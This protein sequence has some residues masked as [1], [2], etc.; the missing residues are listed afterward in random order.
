LQE[1]FN[2][3]NKE[4]IQWLNDQW[5]I[6]FERVCEDIDIQGSPER[7][8][9]RVVIEDKK[10]NLYL[11]EKFSRGR[12]FL[13]K[14]VARAIEF[15][16][17][18]GLNQ[19]LLCK[20]SKFGEFLP[21]YRD[22]CF[23]L[24]PFLDSTELRRPDY[25]SSSEIGQNFALFLIRQNEASENMQT[26]IFFAPFSIKEYI[27]KIFSEMKIHD[28]DIHKKYLPFL[29]FL[30]KEFMENHDSLPLAF[31]HGD[32]HP[33]NIIWDHNEIKAVIDWEFAGY[34][35]DMYDAANLVG[36]A[37]I[38]DPEGLGMPMVMTFIKTLKEKGIISKQGWDMF[39]EYILA[40]RFAWLSEW[41]RKKDEQM[42][43]LEACYLDIL[44][45]NMNR[46]KKTWGI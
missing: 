3:E 44:M 17:D 29:E 1:L 25:L 4:F 43:D 28:I 18:N 40:L 27:Y 5:N 35:P 37:G 24:S 19:A 46:L 26:R 45:N 21:I 42:L 12:F 30:E 31:A 34:K 6:K 39:P 36:C 7:T 16:A 23:Q 20:K 10:S 32:L 41:L 33:L 14:N 15:L 13:R 8:L 38:E 9:S 22:A 2:L 11:L